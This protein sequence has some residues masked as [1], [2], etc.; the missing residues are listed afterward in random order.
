MAKIYGQIWGYARVSTSE[1]NPALQID[2]L[3]TA[4]V[5]RE[6]IVVERISGAAKVRPDDAFGAGSIREDGR[7]MFPAYLFQVKSPA[8]S[9]TAYYHAGCEGGTAAK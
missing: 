3:V 8:D 4:G 9:K 7:G 1:Q 5:P 6:Q 2:A